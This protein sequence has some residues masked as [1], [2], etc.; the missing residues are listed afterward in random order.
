MRPLLTPNRR[1]F[2]SVLFNPYYFLRKLHIPHS[3]IPNGNYEAS[4]SEGTCQ[5][6][7]Q[8]RTNAEQFASFENN[9]IQS[10][11]I[12]LQTKGQLQS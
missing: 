12:H 2:N 11:F 9:S 4:V 1:C 6:Q 5:K 3:N 7:S 8:K 10:L